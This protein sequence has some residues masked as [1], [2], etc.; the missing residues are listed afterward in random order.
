VFSDAAAAMTDSGF[1]DKIRTLARFSDRFDAFRLPAENC[2]VLFAT[3]PPGTRLEPHRHDTDNWGVI[4]TGEMI[5]AVDGA[6]RR[7]RAGDWYHVPAGVEHA[8]RCDV[9]T[10]EI[11]FWFRRES[12]PAGDRR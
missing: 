2:D 12:A 3:Y 4:V 6:E 8:A 7:Y 11:E 1:P 9:L 10:E 5:I